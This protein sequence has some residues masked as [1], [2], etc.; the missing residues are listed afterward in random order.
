MTTSPA[1]TPQPPAD[2]A[3]PAPTPTDAAAPS[4]APAPGPAAGPAPA[5]T[6]P[7]ERVERADAVKEVDA[8]GA[9]RVACGVEITLALVTGPVG[10]VPFQARLT[11]TQADP[12]AV[13][14]HC[15]TSP[16]STVTWVLSRETLRR[17]LQRPSGLGDVHVRPAPG[18]GPH[19]LG[20]ALITLGAGPEAALLRGDTAEIQRFLDLSAAVVPPGQEH[21]HLDL[22]A[23]VAQ[24]RQTP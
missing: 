1:S 20:S 15:Q 5:P 8:P 11:Y 16:T 10:E 24:L 12:Y 23:L 2:R 21:R 9:V 17:G 13:R 6:E 3:R 7:V 19:G 14:L 4:S 18:P 22:D